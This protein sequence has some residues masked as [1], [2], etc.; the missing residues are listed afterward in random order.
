[1]AQCLHCGGQVLWLGKGRRK[2]RGEVRGLVKETRR[3]ISLG[4]YKTQR[5]VPLIAFQ[6]Q[7]KR[8]FTSFSGEQF[9]Q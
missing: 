1:M 2:Y 9:R 7:Q 3:R 8:N 6:L 5:F 4:K